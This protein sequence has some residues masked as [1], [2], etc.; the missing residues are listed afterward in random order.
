[1]DFPPLADPPIDPASGL[2]VVANARG[3]DELGLVEP[4]E[5]RARLGGPFGT[6]EAGERA[7]HPLPAMDEAPPALPAARHHPPPRRAIL[8]RDRPPHL[9]PEHVR[10]RWQVRAEELREPVSRLPQAPQTIE[11][12]RR[13]RETRMDGE[14]ELP[15]AQ[16][17]ERL[18]HLALLEDAIELGA[19]PLL[20]QLLEGPCLA[21]GVHQAE[22]LGARPEIE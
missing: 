10:L 6:R 17:A 5:R 1:P 3:V 14:Q 13:S 20:P 15:L 16:Q 7:A 19:D 18:H 21:R 22:R 11:Q 4:H 12:S 9:D 8:L 2:L